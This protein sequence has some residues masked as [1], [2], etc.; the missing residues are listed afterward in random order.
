MKIALFSA[1]YIL[2]LCC[3]CLT[4]TWA[5]FYQ[6][7]TEAQRVQNYYQNY[8]QQLLYR[9]RTGGNCGLRTSSYLPHK[10]RVQ[11]DELRPRRGR[12]VWEDD[13]SMGAAVAPKGS[14]PWMVSLFVLLKNGEA[15]FM[16]AGALITPNLAVTAAHCFTNNE[17]KTTWFARVGDNYIL[18]S[19]PEE[20]T[21]RVSK[22]VK[23]GNF[24]PLGSKWWGWSQW[25][26]IGRPSASSSLSWP[27]WKLEPSR[28]SGTI[29][30]RCSTHLC[31]ASIGLP[32]AQ[33]DSTTLWNCRVG[34]D[35]V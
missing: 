31:V 27:L 22:I 32:F 20:Q 21:F 16:C 5:Q 7:R 26:C 29:R 19:D 18:K 4:S 33:V 34:H 24:K 12:I 25:Y 10:K 30:A 14:F 11:N 6:R 13:D 28:W 17:K 3:F 9:S 23:H 15:L 35:W 2:L 8:L 1:I